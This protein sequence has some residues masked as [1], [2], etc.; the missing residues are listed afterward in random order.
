MQKLMRPEELA[1]LGAAL[2]E[3]LKNASQTCALPDP[4]TRLRAKTELSG[5]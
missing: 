4:A 5:P 1:A 2:D 3:E